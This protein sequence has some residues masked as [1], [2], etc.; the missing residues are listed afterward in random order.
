[1]TSVIRVWAICADI[2]N[3]SASV[4]C[5]AGRDISLDIFRST[6]T[7]TARGPSTSVGMTERELRKGEKGAR[8]DGAELPSHLEA[9]TEIKLT[10]D[11]IVDKKIFCAFALDA[12][13]INQIRAVHD[14]KGLT[15]VVISNHD[16]KPRFA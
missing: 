1:L 15:N 16:R 12:A 2:V 13:I 10:A 14:G 11:G 7:E 4:S 3:H 6:A 9:L 8:S 5:R